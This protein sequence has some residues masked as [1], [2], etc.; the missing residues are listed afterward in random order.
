MAA[1]RASNL[2]LSAFLGWALAREL[3]PDD[4]SSA[5]LA[6]VAAP[7]LTWW[8][9]PT[10]VAAMAALLIL[11]RLVARTTGKAP[12]GF[13]QV[14]LVI[15]GLWASRSLSG[16]LLALGLSFAVARD[17]RLPGSTSRLQ[18]ITALAIGF[19]STISL[20]LSTP[21]PDRDWTVALLAFTAIALLS[22]A[23]LRITRPP[24][25]T[26]DLTGSPLDVTRIRSARRHVVMLCAAACLVLGAS[27]AV[28]LVPALA[29]LVAT[30]SRQQLT[31]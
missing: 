10:T 20:A 18:L 8:A 23:T 14:V 12:T 17:V 19:A 25:S 31:G 27:A 22:G 1:S 21:A 11:T 24:T 6:A 29:A 7:I 28:G 4:P 5:T 9:G 2:A 13:D 16:W 3:D 30:R 15:L 26:G